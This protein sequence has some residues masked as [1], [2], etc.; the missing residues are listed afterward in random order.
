MDLWP[1]ADFGRPV[2]PGRDRFVLRLVEVSIMRLRLLFVGLMLAATTLLAGC[3]HTGCC[4]RPAPP[5]PCCG[6]PS[7][8]APYPATSGYVP[9][10]TPV[11]ATVPGPGAP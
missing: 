8:Y 7:G 3:D 6:Q 1:R 5:Q 2:I 10:R 4:H 11:I 9:A